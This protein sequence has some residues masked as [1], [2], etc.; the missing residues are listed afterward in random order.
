MRRSGTAGGNCGNDT[1]VSTDDRLSVDD[2]AESNMLLW[3]KL[4]EEMDFVELP[5]PTCFVWFLFEVC[6]CVGVFFF[7]IVFMNA[8]IRYWEKRKRNEFQLEKM[9]GN[10]LV[11]QTC[12]DK[13]TDVS[14]KSNNVDGQCW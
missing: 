9:T 7:G 4:E 14:R 3:V 2:F 13:N 6:F 12:I 8:S 11:G 5:A 1:I 10:S